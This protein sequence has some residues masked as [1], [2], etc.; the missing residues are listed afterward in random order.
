MQ[1]RKGDI[2]QVTA[3]KD[4]GKKGK[5]LRVL[6]RANKVVVEDINRVKKHQKP[7][8]AIPQGGILRIE[9]PMHASNVM[10]LCNKCDKPT[11]VG[12]KILDNQE[13]VRVCKKCG[14]IID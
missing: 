9:T 3:G 6:P 12:S 10:L 5:V 13:K 4:I 11:R 2:V 1:I 7:N 14:E 8:R